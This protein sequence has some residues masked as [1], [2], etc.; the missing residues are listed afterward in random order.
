MERFEF[1]VWLDNL[2]KMFY[3]YE[4]GALIPFFLDVLPLDTK[5]VLM[6]CTG[7][8]DS[9]GRLIFEG[10]I[11]E[12]GMWKDRYTIVFRGMGFWFVDEENDGYVFSASSYDIKV[13]GNIYE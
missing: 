10:D 8:K 13:I 3:S 11:V 9:E 7:Q 6:Q 1:R 2:Q 4:Y 12:V 5:D